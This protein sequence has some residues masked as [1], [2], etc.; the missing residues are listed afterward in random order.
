[1]NKLTYSNKPKK[2]TEFRP[3]DIFIRTVQ[4]NELLIL[5]KINNQFSLINLSDGIDYSG[6]YRTI[7]TLIKKV[8]HLIKFYGRN[9]KIQI[10]K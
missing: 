1:M 8:G 6:S 2:E 5:I 9:V 3:G 10:S 7:K 4:K